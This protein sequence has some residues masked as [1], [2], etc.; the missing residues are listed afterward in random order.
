MSYCILCGKEITF[1]NKGF[2]PKFLINKGKLCSNCSDYFVDLSY[3]ERP[4]NENQ[5]NKIK[6]Y[7]TKE[8]CTDE[9]MGIIN[10]FLENAREE[11]DSSKIASELN[12]EEL[13]E[14]QNKLHQQNYDK[15]SSANIE[16]ENKNRK[17]NEIKNQVYL[18]RLKNQG[19]EGYYEYKVISIYDETGW[20]NKSSGSID[21][22]AMTQQLCEL[23]IQ[24]WHLSTAY[25]N[26]LGKNSLAALGSTIGLGVNSTVD[27]H[28][29]IF[30]RFVKF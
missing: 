18:E 13:K 23:G 5:Y 3:N 26:E 15:K 17:N 28:I 27:Q 29:L 7:F 14:Y 19:C 9:G 8:V 1:L 6:N 21:I 24:G 2:V 30:E 22:N 10:Q 4:M 11:L 25:T 16:L 12:G 20:F